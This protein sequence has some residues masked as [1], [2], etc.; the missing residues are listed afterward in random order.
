MSKRVRQFAR[1]RVRAGFYGS[2]QR[3]TCIVD[4]PRMFVRSNYAKYERTEINLR[5]NV[6]SK[7]CFN[8]AVFA[9]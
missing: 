5:R 3:R 6:G 2:F 4:W 9:V 8:D 1:G 7:T